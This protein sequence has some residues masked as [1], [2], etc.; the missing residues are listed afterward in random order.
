MYFARGRNN[1]IV[2]NATTNKEHQ[3]TS[4]TKFSLD[5]P[6][7]KYSS[8]QHAVHRVDHRQRQRGTTMAVGAGRS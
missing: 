4:F 6:E 5:G 2:C 3:T 1:R 8:V 7:E